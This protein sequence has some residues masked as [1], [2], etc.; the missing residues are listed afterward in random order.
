M[1][2]NKIYDGIDASVYQG[3]IEWP[4]YKKEHDFVILKCSTTY[5][6]G[7]IK[8][9]DKFDDNYK[10]AKN[11]G[12]KY[13]GVYHFSRA[14]TEEKAIEEA[15]VTL[16]S[17]K[18]LN[19]TPQDLIFGVWYD[20]EAIEMRALG[21]KEL[22]KIFLT[23]KNKMNSHGYPVGIY[24]NKEWL[25][26]VWDENFFVNNH[27]PIWMAQ[28]YK[29]ITYKNPKVVDIWQKSSTYRNTSFCCNDMD[30]NDLFTPVDK[31]FKKQLSA[32]SQDNRIIASWKYFNEKW[33]ATDFYGN[34]LLD[35]MYL[36]KNNVPYYF[37]DG[38]MQSLR[39][40]EIDENVWI[41]AQDDGS[42]AR[43]CILCIDN[44]IYGFNDSYIMLT[45]WHEIDGVWY[46]F[47]ERTYL[48]DP[49]DL[50]K[51]VPIG[52][53]LKDGFYLVGGKQFHFSKDGKCDSNKTFTVKAD[54]DCY[55]TIR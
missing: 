44:E 31:L 29:E 47:S 42:L 2:P 13:I 27:S 8:I 25:T 28:Y 3:E 24:T 41:Y 34:R 7:K 50:N 15:E 21:T 17:I 14:T 11:A 12:I 20:I 1:Y 23:F 26:N 37:I 35:G 5:R 55:L 51:K 32:I 48:P 16:N 9:A 39:W 40:I 19:I 18:S 36:D 4:N 46:Y 33:M 52:A 6:D 10:G 45:G 53:A 30:L 54:N 22:E 38:W 49:A 43:N